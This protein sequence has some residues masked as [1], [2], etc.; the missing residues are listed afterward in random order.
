MIVSSRSFCGSHT[1]HIDV[2]KCS[3]GLR[4]L[5]ELTKTLSYDIV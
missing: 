3:L 2:G 5:N 4:V 1:G